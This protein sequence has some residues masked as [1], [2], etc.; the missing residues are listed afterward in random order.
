MRFCLIVSLL[1]AA[2]AAQSTTIPLEQEPALRERVTKFY[3]AISEGKYKNAF[4]LVADD[5][6]N[7]FM[8]MPKLAMKDVAIATVEGLDGGKTAKVVVIFTRHSGTNRN[9]WCEEKT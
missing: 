5:A 9:R 4:S 1:T 8:G 3:A 2:A 6:Q 7:A